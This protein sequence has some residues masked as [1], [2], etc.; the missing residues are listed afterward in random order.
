MADY[1]VHYAQA[2]HN[3]LT[4]T[5]L[6]DEP[7]HHDWGITAAFYSAIHYFECW[8]FGET[9]KH[10]E[11]SIPVDPNN[12][13]WKFSPHAWREKLVEQKMSRNAFKAFRKLRENSETSRY[14]TFSMAPISMPAA[15]F[16]KP[17]AAKKIVA[18]ELET[19]LS[20]LRIP[21]RKFVYS[22]ELDQSIGPLAPFIIRSMFASFSDQTQF[23]QTSKSDLTK[24]FGAQ[25]SALIRAVEA[26]GFSFSV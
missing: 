17:E 21:W 26:K 7:P 19:F 5:K 23:L 20:E 22:L 15:Q 25:T 1:S 13:R 12:N 24:I 9:E 16:F 4:A 18:V 11:T 10:T 14:L 6:V 2:T 3:R 8:L